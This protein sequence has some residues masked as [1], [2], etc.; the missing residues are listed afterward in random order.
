LRTAAPFLGGKMA[1]EKSTPA[2]PTPAPAIAFDAALERV[3]FGAGRT[4]RDLRARGEIS[5]G[6]PRALSIEGV[7]G[8]E[9]R[10]RA[11]LGEG[12]EKQVVA[13]A[14][15]DASALF[16]T[17]TQP[18]RTVQLPPG[19]FAALAA[20]LGNVPTLV[21]GGS[22]DLRGEVSAQRS[23]SGQFRLGRA[24]VL[25]PPRILQL[26]A[27]KSAQTWKQQPLLESFS[28]ERVAADAGGVML[29]GL[30]IVGSGLIDRLT[31]RAAS[32]RF[33][34]GRIAADVDYFGVGLD[35]AGTRADPQVYLKDKG[36]LVR[37]FGQPVEFDF[38]RMA[39]EA[40]EKKAAQK[41]R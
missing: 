29:G 1:P 13:L 33:A 28:I 3:E 37:T 18:L 4:L 19:D 11:T 41:K 6:W 31:V 17:L 25:R 27:L 26:L 12:A 30:T 38:E 9:N 22:V 24:T 7:E 15:G 32:Y 34:D 39:A 40:E 8:N 14:I 10:L 36:L 35:V 2:A 20:Q 16:A 21:A 23:F 5:A